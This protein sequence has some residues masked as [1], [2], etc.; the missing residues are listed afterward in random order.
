M[1][2]PSMSVRYLDSGAVGTEVSP[3]QEVRAI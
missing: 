2:G 3:G 1:P